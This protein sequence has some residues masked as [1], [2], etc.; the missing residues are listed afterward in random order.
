MWKI[1][2][3]PHFKR[4]LKPLSKKFRDLENSIIAELENF[5]P[6]YGTLIDYNIY[7]IRL[8]T[9]SLQRGKSGGFRIY[10]YV[11]EVKNVIVPIT[12]YFKSEKENL[13]IQELKEHAKIINQELDL[14]LKS[15]I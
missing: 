14:E 7:K 8:T 10:T 12:I 6:I 11:F 3:L 4:T 1:I 9:K 15:E 2:L 13:T 5:N